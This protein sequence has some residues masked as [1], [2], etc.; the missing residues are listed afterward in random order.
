MESD[1]KFADLIKPLPRRAQ[2]LVALALSIAT[3][4]T[5]FLVAGRYG[6][7]CVTCP[8]ILL[9][10][11]RLLRATYNATTNHNPNRNR[12]HSPPLSVVATRVVSGT[13]AGEGEYPFMASLHQWN[14]DMSRSR[15]VCGGT[16]I[17]LDVIL[18]AAQCNFSRVELGVIRTSISPL[19][20]QAE[21]EGRIMFDVEDADKRSHPYYNYNG[22]TNYNFALV[23]L[24]Q[25][26]NAYTGGPISVARLH[27]PVQALP[28][29]VNFLRPQDEL[30]VIGYGRTSY[31]GENSEVMEDASVRYLS[32]NECNRRHRRHDVAITGDM[33]CAHSAEGRDACTGDIGGPLVMKG[34]HKDAFNR[35]DIIV[36][37]VSFRK[38]CGDLYYPGVY[39]RV[40]E[41]YRWIERTVCNDLSPQSCDSN[42]RIRNFWPESPGNTHKEQSSQNCQDSIRYFLSTTGRS[43]KMLSCRWV[44][45]NKFFR[46]RSY[47]NKCPRTCRVEQCRGVS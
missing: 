11:A 14:A 21:D 31:M 30:H 32:N 18:T 42:G 8:P 15:H 25:R 23:R 43:K 17:T 28:S 12:K 29:G 10:P 27:N 47:K 38:K 44:Q 4:T 39:S 9:R 33:L 45:K 13:A 34:S 16:L 24:P 46:C 22:H 3:A 41:G 19:H 20:L 37:I 7:Y 2:P 6:W 40:S 35:R 5:Y 1:A 36:G 26:V